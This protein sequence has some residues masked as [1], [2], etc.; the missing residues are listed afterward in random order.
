MNNAQRTLA[1]LNYQNYDRLPIVHFRFWSETLKKWM[2]EG[3]IPKAAQNNGHF[4]EDVVNDAASRLGFDFEWMISFV[5]NCFLDPGFDPIIIKKFP[6]GSEHFQ[7]QEGVTLLKVR[8][9][10]SIPSEIDHLLKDRASWE[11][12]YKPRL[13]WSEKRV[14]NDWSATLFNNESRPKGIECGSLLGKLRNAMGIEGLSYLMADD[15]KLFDEIIQTIG[16]LCYRNVRLALTLGIHFDYA[17][18]WEDIS[19]KNGPLINPKLFAEKFGPHYKKI[20]D[21]LKKAGIGIISVDSD[22]LIDQLIPTWLN[23]GVNTMFPI[24]VGTWDASIQPW[25]EKYGKEIRGVG[26]VNKHIFSLDRKAIDIEIE[27]LKPLVA[28]G[29]YIPCPDHHI[30]PDAQWD[31]VHYYCDKMHATF[32]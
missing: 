14:V 9:V 20:T 4:S 11:K 7:N 6:D 26:G 32:G 24:E 22:G 27:R 21:E 10:I 1:V 28:L 31:L 19:F 25:R 5:P 30:P 23:N 16:D 8:D 17:H 2:Y 29:G 3:H 12:Y 13:Q 18:F 15:E